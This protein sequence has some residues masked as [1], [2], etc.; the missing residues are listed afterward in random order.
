MSEQ[1]KEHSE[2]ED[3]Q[4]GAPRLVTVAESI[5]YR[6]RAQQAENRLQEFEQSLAE[7]QAQLEERNDELA[8]AEA[9]RDE[10]Q[11]RLNVA[12]NRT[13]A[14]RML[15]E[16]GVVDL[17]TA[18]MLLSKRVDLGAAVDRD[19]LARSVEHLILDKPFLRK[20]T[21]VSLPPTSA[22]AKPSQPSPAARLTEAAERAVRTG[23][24]KD[25]AEY[26]RL[27]RQAATTGCST[28]L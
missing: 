1:L 26:L 2:Q 13:L 5:K 7:L 16:S 24:R 22:S 15:S 21:N 28:P 10:M 11:H 17:E 9:Q 12:E 27:R 4:N 8:T 14:E 18:S 25:V 3:P 6:R 19:A 20:G 23:D